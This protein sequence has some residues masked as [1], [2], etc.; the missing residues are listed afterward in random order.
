MDETPVPERRDWNQE[1]FD[2]YQSNRERSEARWAEREAQRLDGTEPSLDLG[3]YAGAFSHAAWGTIDL[4][5]DGS[6]L[7]LVTPNY[8]FP[9][10]HWHLDTFLLD[11]PLWGWKEFVN[12]KIGPDG[13][14]VS[15]EFAGE[16]LG[17]A[18]AGPSGSAD[19]Q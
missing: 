19:A 7:V 17:K 18:A 11:Y 5:R 12:F 1:V 3:D 4:R 13:R 2:L 14:V 15:M 9:L 8:E 10:V 16:V 6:S